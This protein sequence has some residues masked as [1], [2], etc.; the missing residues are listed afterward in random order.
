LVFQPGRV[1]R[2][3]A[4]PLATDLPL[5]HRS[6]AHRAGVAAP[7]HGVHR[8][9][10]GARACLSRD[11]HA[12]HNGQC[13]SVV[14]LF[15]DMFVF[16]NPGD[17]ARGTQA[18]HTSPLHLPA[19]GEVQPPRFASISSSTVRIL[20]S[21]P[22]HR[23]VEGPSCMEYFEGQDGCPQDKGSRRLSHRSDRIGSDRI[24]SDRI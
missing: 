4:Q 12:T 11:R 20:T 1:W 13:D 23:D 24:G 3:S 9:A 14:T 6:G 15:G 18:H 21:Q 5:A 16:S 19:V 22:P 2:A 8:A 7:S 10:A 17:R